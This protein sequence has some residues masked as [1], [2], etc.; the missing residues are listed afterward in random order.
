MWV[1]EHSFDKVRLLRLAEMIW[2][3]SARPRRLGDR[4]IWRQLWLRLLNTTRMT[5]E[6]SVTHGSAAAPGPFEPCPYLRLRASRGWLLTQRSRWSPASGPPGGA[7]RRLRNEI[8]GGVLF[9]AFSRGRYATD[10]SHYQVMPLGIVLPKSVAEAERTIA[11]ARADGVSVLPP[12]RR[13]VAMRAD[14][15]RIAC[16]RLLAPPRPHSGARCCRAALRGRARH[17]ARRPQSR[18]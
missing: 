4:S 10:A 8:T 5:K 13:H 9:D 3:N 15:Q 17:C 11:V 12:R 2:I 7:E 18:A 16:G 14:G 6:L 1:C